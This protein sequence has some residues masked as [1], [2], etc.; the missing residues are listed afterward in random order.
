MKKFIRSV[1]KNVSN[2]KNPKY[3]ELK[4]NGSHYIDPTAYDAIKKIE[5]D[6]MDRFNKLLAIIKGTCEIAGFKIENRIVLRDE[7]TG[8]VWK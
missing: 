7:K 5:A 8:R 6:E 2:E 1:R 3:N 4:Y